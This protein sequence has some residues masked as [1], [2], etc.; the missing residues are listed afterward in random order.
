MLSYKYTVFSSERS[1]RN[2]RLRA[3]RQTLMCFCWLVMWKCVQTLQMV[4]F[5]AWISSKYLNGALCFFHQGPRKNIWQTLQQ[6][7]DIT[8]L[9]TQDTHTH[10]NK[11]KDTLS[12]KILIS[13]LAVNTHRRHIKLLRTTIHCKHHSRS[14][15]STHDS[16][17]CTRESTVWLPECTLYR[18]TVQLPAS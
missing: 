18:E 1:T 6:H 5:K 3:A 17:D 16:Y 9:T 4:C 11:G 14:C 10:T 15:F 13:L 8:V 12:I 2:L 7:P